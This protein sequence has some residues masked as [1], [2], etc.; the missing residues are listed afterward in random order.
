MG[1]FVYLLQKVQAAFAATTFI[2]AER[3]CLS[4]WPGANVRGSG[5]E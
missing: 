2:F 4:M 1:A 3:L 5:A